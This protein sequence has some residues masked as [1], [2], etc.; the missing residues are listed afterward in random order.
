[1]ELLIAIAV[2]WF[3][4]KLFTDDFGSTPAKPP[5]AT[6]PTPYRSPPSTSSSVTRAAP[7]VIRPTVVT[8]PPAPSSGYTPRP[9]P[10]DSAVYTYVAGAPHRIGKGTP[11]ETVFYTGQMLTAERERSNRHDSNA[12]KLKIGQRHVGYVPKEVNEPLAQHMDYGGSLSVRVT[13]VNAD[14]RW[15]GVRIAV[16]AV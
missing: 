15:L 9:R 8:P 1:M 2:I 12:I 5:P 7:P 6:R 3:L 16:T 13:R 4:L 11:V 10:S 14:D